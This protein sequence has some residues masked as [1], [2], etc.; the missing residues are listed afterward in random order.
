MNE[1]KTPKKLVVVVL[2]WT[3]MS[4]GLVTKIAEIK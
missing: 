2:F 1:E 4:Y 3:G